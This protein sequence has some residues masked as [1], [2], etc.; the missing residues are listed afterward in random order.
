MYVCM[1]VYIYVCV[2]IYIYVNVHKIPTWVQK[3]RGAFGGSGLDPNQETC[4]GAGQRSM[5]HKYVSYVISLC[6]FVI[7]SN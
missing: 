3:T 2:Y 7:V 5:L 6:Y 1:C 4:A